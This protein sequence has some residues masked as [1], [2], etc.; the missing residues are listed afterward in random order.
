LSLVY[1]GKRPE[2][3]V[4]AGNHIMRTLLCDRQQEFLLPATKIRKI[5]GDP[6][7]NGYT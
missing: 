5:S 2:G 3:V 1:T 7:S 4:V 6:D